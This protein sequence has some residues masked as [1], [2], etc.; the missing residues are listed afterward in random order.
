QIFG[1]P[2][3]QVAT[4]LL[5]EGWTTSKGLGNVLVSDQDCER[6][7]LPGR[8]ALWHSDFPYTFPMEPLPAL[9]VFAV[10]GNTAAGGGGTLLV[11]GSHRMVGRFA[12]R[13]PELAAEPAKRARAACHQSNGW[14]CDLTSGLGGDPDRVERFMGAAT[15]VDGIPAHVVEACGQAG[16]VF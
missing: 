16:D 13:H 15:D 11:A 3:R 14:L 2:L 4:A 6:W 5:G 1:E 7:D 10:F 12:D 9:R 8:E